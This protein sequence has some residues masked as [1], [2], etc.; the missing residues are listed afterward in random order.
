[1]PF[2]QNIP[3]RWDETRLLSGTPGRDAV[4]ARRSGDRWFVGGMRAGAGEPLQL[5][6]AGLTRGKRVLVD[7][8]T[9]DGTNG[10]ATVHTTVRA[11]SSE[12][13]RVPTA[14]NGGFVAVVCDAARPSPSRPSQSCLEPVEAWPDA[15]LTV[16]PAEA[17]VAPGSV[18]ELRATFAVADRAVSRVRLTP[19][20]PEGWSADQGTQTVS[21]LAAGQSAQVAWQV[22]VP[23]EAQTGTLATGTFEVPVDVEYRAGR[24]RYVAAN[25]ATLWVTPPALTGAHHISDL[26]WIEQSNGYGPIERDR[27]NGQAAGGDGRPIKIAGVTYAKGVGMHATGSLTAWLGGTCTTFRAVVGID[28]EVLE[29]P[30]ESG[31]GSVRFQVYGDGVLLTET[32]VL[33]NDDGG[34]PLEVDVTGVRRLRLVADEGGDG[35]NFDHA[36][37]ADASVECG[38]A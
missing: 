28:D 38:P 26:D 30:G 19:D 14:D 25:Q 2:L 1:M 23:A 7:L 33:T 24:G 15:T 31:T 18:V 34:V 37:W 9:D 27:S 35:K 29:T 4:L 17:D 6:L 36:D 32:P 10:S 12:T 5:P 8:L 11:T 3:A 20:L 16:D 21:R 22:R 13:L